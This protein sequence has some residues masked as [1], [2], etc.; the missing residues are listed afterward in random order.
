MQ[1]I[2]LELVGNGLGEKGRSGRLA[3]RRGESSDGN[4]KK[5]VEGGR[6]KSK[7]QGEMWSRAGEGWREAGEKNEEVVH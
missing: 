6:R 7:G 4:F 3:R 2:E 5:A 1:K